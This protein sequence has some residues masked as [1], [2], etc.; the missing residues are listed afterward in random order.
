MNRRKTAP[1]RGVL[2][3]ATA[4][5]R[6]YQHARYHPSPDLEPYVE[7]YWSVAWDLRGMAPERAETLPHP[8]VHMIF[9]RS[10]GGRITGVMRGK[11]SRVL[12]GEGGVLAAKFT[13][14]GFYPFVGVPIST[15]A[16]TTVG[17]GGVFGARGDAL[18]QAVLAETDDASRIAVVEA[19]LR[20]R[21]PAAD[22]TAALMTEMVYDVARDRGIVSVDD[23]V[24]RHRMNKRTLQR[25]FAK[26]VGV[27]PKWVIQRYRLHEAAARLAADPSIAQSALA[28]DL[29][30]SDQA[31]FIRDFKALVGTSPAAYARAAARGRRDRV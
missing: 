17:I 25:L 15:F 4:D 9:E 22:E 11:F 28:T 13:P 21:R 5:P 31:H 23:L 6:R 16:D 20:E 14:A 18:E 19:F 10:V 24:A 26:Y 7:H 29:G 3:T 27:S 8:S 1:P 30:Y 12:E 2:N